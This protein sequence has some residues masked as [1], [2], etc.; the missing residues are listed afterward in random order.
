[1]DVT[2]L[3]GVVEHP[4][5]HVKNFR[6]ARDQ[7]RGTFASQVMV[8]LVVYHLVQYKLLHE[9]NIRNFETW[10]SREGT[11]RCLGKFLRRETQE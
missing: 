1:M 8:L 3:R 11:A 10:L 7:F 5:S 9:I 6:I 2:H 4:Y